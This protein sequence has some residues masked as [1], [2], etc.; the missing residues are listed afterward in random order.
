MKGTS[1]GNRD[2][3]KPPEFNQFGGEVSLILDYEFQILITGQG[4][5]YTIQQ[6]V[7]TLE[8]PVT[9]EV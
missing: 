4:P 8:Y 1:A 5:R 3:A 6:T 9:R 7:P 2:F